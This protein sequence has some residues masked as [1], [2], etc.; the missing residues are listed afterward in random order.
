M[1][2]QHVDQLAALAHPQRLALFRLLVRRYPDELSAGEI[3]AVL[4]V[5]QNTL[6][7]YLNSLRQAGL[8]LQKRDGRSLLYRADMGQAGALVSYLVTDCC[9][10]RPELCPPLPDLGSGGTAM[11]SRPYN[12]L[13]ICTGN[14]ARSIFGEALL[15]DLGGG[16]FNAYSAGTRPSSD[17][18]LV[19]L[20]VLK[21]NGHDISP[22]RAKNIDEF[23]SDAAPKMDFV[24]TVCDQAANEDCPAWS[25]QPITAHW[26][27]PD[28]GKATGTEAER[29]LAFRQAYGALRRRVEAFVSL[30]LEALD[31]LALQRAVDDLAAKKDLA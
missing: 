4:G 1:E 8:I 20:S 7:T 31:R 24:F 26:G 2:S 19:A 30:N 12:V 18:N 9:R 10:G 13:F 16:R 11:S 22:L 21:A 14:S 3:A 6:S 27:L 25:G 5:R 17:L 29:R 15:S 23:R 28:P